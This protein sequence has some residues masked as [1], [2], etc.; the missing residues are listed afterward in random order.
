M[1][2]ICMGNFRI[3]EVKISG[4]VVHLCFHDNDLELISIPSKKSI[5]TVVNSLKNELTKM[6]YEIPKTVRIY[7]S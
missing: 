7:L 3:E 1:K 5:V 6:G 4:Q 2:S